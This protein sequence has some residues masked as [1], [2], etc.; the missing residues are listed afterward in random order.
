M[1]DG[2]IVNAECDQIEVH[3]DFAKLVKGNKFGIYKGGR[4]LPCIYDAIDEL[5][6][7]YDDEGH[8][9]FVKFYKVKI[10]NKCGIVDNKFNYITECRYDNVDEV[11]GN[12]FIAENNGLYTL[13]NIRG[14]QVLSASYQSIITPQHYSECFAEIEDDTDEMVVPDDINSR[15]II[16]FSDSEIQLFDTHTDKIINGKYDK[17]EFESFHK[18]D[19]GYHKFY[20]YILACSN[21]KMSLIVN[22][23][24]ILDSVDDIWYIY[25]ECDERTNLFVFKRDDNIGVVNCLGEIIIPPHQ[26]AVLLESAELED[27]YDSVFYIWQNNSC[28]CYD[29]YGRYIKEYPENLPFANYRYFDDAIRGYHELFEISNDKM[30]GA[31]WP[32]KVE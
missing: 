21:N 32:I 27:K 12:Y 31:G 2:S 3:S 25:P 4:I 13:L 14:E 10:D 18:Y 24:L 17:L 1:D 16:L 23:K 15:Y 28:H 7:L 8:Y 20:S 9:L 26:D 30:N 6:E 29:R 22:G 11:G 19:P 5:L